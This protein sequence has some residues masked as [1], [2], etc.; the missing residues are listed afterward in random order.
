MCSGWLSAGWALE[1]Q[2]IPVNREDAAMRLSSVVDGH[3]T[4]FG[5]WRNHVIRTEVGHFG[6]THP[7]GVAHQI[8]DTAMETGFRTSTHQTSLHNP[9][10]NNSVLGT[11]LISAV[12][13]PIM[14]P[15][16]L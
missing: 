9:A 4:P 1:I 10:S 2:T 3:C 5:I 6:E 14:M 15:A 11:W 13:W 8:A 7:S 12:I 16:Q